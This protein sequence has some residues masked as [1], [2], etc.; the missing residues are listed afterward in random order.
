MNWNI[1]IGL[2]T[3]YNMSYQGYNDLFDTGEAVFAV[4]VL[5]S[6]ETWQSKKERK[7]S[8]SIPVWENEGDFQHSA[9]GHAKIGGSCRI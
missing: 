1:I 8:I 7:R 5:N 2:T 6:K 4:R 9:H 3:V